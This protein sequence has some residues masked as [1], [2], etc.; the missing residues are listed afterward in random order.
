MNLKDLN[1]EVENLF[2]Y[3]KSDLW[4]AEIT[5]IRVNG[6]GKWIEFELDGM[7]E[8]VKIDD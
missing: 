5:D 1:K 4:D 6:N 3:S 8:V 7:K 2:F